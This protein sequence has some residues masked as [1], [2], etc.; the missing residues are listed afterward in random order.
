MNTVVR[1]I[2]FLL[3]LSI[4][5]SNKAADKGKDALPPMPGYKPK[6][7]DDKKASKDEWERGKNEQKEKEK[8][9]NEEIEKE[10][11][12]NNE[13]NEDYKNTNKNTEKMI[14]DMNKNNNNDNNNNQKQTEAKNTESNP[15]IAQEELTAKNGACC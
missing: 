1:S 15:L 5:I 12:G 2:L 13:K 9:E 3:F 7:E 4:Y 10:Q 6:K 11:R 8:K 14:K